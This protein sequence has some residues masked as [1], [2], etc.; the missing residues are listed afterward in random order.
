MFNVP[1]KRTDMGGGKI[2]FHADE[3]YQDNITFFLSESL[4]IT[5]Y[6]F[7]SLTLYRHCE[8]NNMMPVGYLEIFEKK[9]LFRLN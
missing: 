8:I 6:K 9:E 1:V 5:M 2:G 4:S 7:Q 3:V